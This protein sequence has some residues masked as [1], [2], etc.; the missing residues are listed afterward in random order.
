MIKPPII[1]K[2]ARIVCPIFFSAEVILK[3]KLMKTQTMILFIIR[4]ILKIKYDAKFKNW[5]SY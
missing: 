2:R 4:K 5:Q 3:L 1:T